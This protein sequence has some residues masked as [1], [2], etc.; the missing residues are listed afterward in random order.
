MIGISDVPGH[1]EIRRAGNRVP[2]GRRDSAQGMFA[3]GEGFH[4]H[5]CDEVCLADRPRLSARWRAPSAIGLQLQGALVDVALGQ[6]QGL[7]NR[8]GGGLGRLI[9]QGVQQ[10]SIQRGLRDLGF[11]RRADQ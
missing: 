11:K 9:L 10:G 4:V 2:D 3:A 5:E 1:P 6:A 8:A 7:G